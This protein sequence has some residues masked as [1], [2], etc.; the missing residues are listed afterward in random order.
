MMQL[1]A[2]E[3]IYIKRGETRTVTFTLSADDLSIVDSQM[4][5]VVEPGTF[6]VLVGA[7]SN[8]IRLRGKLTVSPSEKQ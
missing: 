8:D 4:R 3:R 6:T 5:R 1:K 7:A 2:F